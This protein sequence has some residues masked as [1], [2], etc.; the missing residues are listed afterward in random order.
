MPSR[1]L[2]GKENNRFSFVCS[3]GNRRVV[4]VRGTVGSFSFIL[5]KRGIPLE[6]SELT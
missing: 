6:A 4:E 3:F 1:F 5:N 2:F